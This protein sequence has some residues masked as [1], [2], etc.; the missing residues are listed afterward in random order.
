MIPVPIIVKAVQHHLNMRTLPVDSE[1]NVVRTHPIEEHKHCST[2]SH[3]RIL[4][5]VLRNPEKGKLGCRRSDTD[6][7]LNPRMTQAD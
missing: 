6:S 4:N 1:C 2:L 5:R 3:E 7:W